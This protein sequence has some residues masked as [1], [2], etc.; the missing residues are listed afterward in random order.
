MMC[1]ACRRFYKHSKSFNAQTQQPETS[2]LRRSC[3]CGSCDSDPVTWLRS[4]YFGWSF[5]WSGIKLY[6]VLVVGSTSTAN[7]SMPNPTRA[8]NAAPWLPTNQTIVMPNPMRPPVITISLVPAKPTKNNS[9]VIS[10]PCSVASINNSKEQDLAGPWNDLLLLAAALKWKSSAP[11]RAHH[12]RQSIIALLLSYCDSKINHH[13]WCM[14]VDRMTNTE[15]RINND[16][17]SMWFNQNE[18]WQRQQQ[19]SQIQ[20][21]TTRVRWNTRRHM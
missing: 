6:V 14:I 10:E 16:W 20:K 12:H 1:R 2:S 7:H 13:C 8:D 18:E 5:V 9:R 17:C 19:L 15:E 4:S 21:C 11:S 3:H